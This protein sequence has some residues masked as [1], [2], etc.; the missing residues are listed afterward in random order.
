MDDLEFALVDETSF[1]DIP[2]PVAP[3]A[4]CQTC[5]YWE[6]L[7]GSRAAPDEG[8]TD[9]T[10]RESLKRSRLLAGR[11]VSGSYAMLAYRSDAVARTPVGY[12][13]FGPLSAYPRAQ[14]IRD[15]YPGLPE[16]PAPWVVTCLQAGPATSAEDRAAIG[17]ALLAA[18][19]DELDH[20]GITAVE[21]YP[22]GVAEPWVPSPGPA[23]IYESSGFERAAG[24][25]R[26]PVY[27]RELSGETDAD[28]W[29]GLLRAATPEDEGDGWPLPMPARRDPDDLF[30]LPPEGPK[31]PNP[32]GDDD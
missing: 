1:A 31:R 27:R 11:S 30:R 20:R 8:A 10:A 14:D 28:A 32:F 4:R 3:G 25:E 21:A 17:T 2:G 7:D 9:G 22:E 5:D 24:D 13:Q 19:C 15:R 26:Y 23:S 6:R 18:V 16:S 12:A 29:A